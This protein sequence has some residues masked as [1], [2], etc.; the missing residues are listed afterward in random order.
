MLLDVG[1]KQVFIQQQ[2]N[3]WNYVIDPVIRQSIPIEIFLLLRCLIPIP[4]DETLK[5][6]YL[7]NWQQTFEIPLVTEYTKED[8]KKM[9]NNHRS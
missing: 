9:T 8:Y 3:L 6:L 7:E 4:M 1:L 2:P 5:K